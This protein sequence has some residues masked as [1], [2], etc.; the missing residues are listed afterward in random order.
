MSTDCNNNKSSS[1][2][3]P[4]KQDFKFPREDF[5]QV[6]QPPDQ[7]ALRDLWQRLNGYMCIALLKI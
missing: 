7:E 3:L 2:F 6:I 4:M 1:L 5:R